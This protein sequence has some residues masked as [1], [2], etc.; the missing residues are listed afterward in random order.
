MFNTTFFNSYHKPLASF[1]TMVPLADAFK[2]MQAHMQAW[3]VLAASQSRTLQA[4]FSSA[5]QALAT[6]QEPQAALAVMKD[7]AE[8]GFALSAQ[9][10]QAASKL[11]CGQCEGA[12]D[13]LDKAQLEAFLS[14]GKALRFTS[15]A[16]QS[17]AQ[18]GVKA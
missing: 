12:M 7:S 4:C 5:A 3:S 8:R 18:P 1:Q 17:Q 15:A 13:E 6:A 2:P 11:L 14:A 10:V 16:L 9:H